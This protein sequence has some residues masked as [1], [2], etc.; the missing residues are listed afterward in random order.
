[1]S[2]PQRVQVKAQVK[3]LDSQR[4]IRRRHVKIMTFAGFWQ[5]LDA[6]P[7]PP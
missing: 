7:D 1:M 6:G 3:T 4:F 5:N 2:T